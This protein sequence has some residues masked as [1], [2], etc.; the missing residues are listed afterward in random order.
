MLDEKRR[1]GRVRDIL[2][3]FYVDAV[4]YVRMFY[5][6][7]LKTL[8][9]SDGDLKKIVYSSK[10]IPSLEQCLEYMLKTGCM[11]QFSSLF[12]FFSYLINSITAIFNQEQHTHKKAYTFIYYFNSFTLLVSINKLS[13][14]VAYLFSNFVYFTTETQLFFSVSN[15]K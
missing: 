1:A 15:S 8:F 2:E 11:L 7:F 14:F 10:I 6:F 4:N 5:I 9:T 12:F 3:Q 13:L